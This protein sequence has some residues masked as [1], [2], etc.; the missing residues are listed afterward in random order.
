MYN[1]LYD[2]SGTQTTDRIFVHCTMSFGIRC[3]K[4][5]IWNQSSSGGAFS[6]GLFNSAPS[7]QVISLNHKAWN[8]AI[9][10]FTWPR[11][12]S[13]V[14]SLVN[15]FYIFSLHL[16]TWCCV[17]GNPGDFPFEM[18]LLLFMIAAIV[19]G[20]NLIFYKCKSP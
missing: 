4:R 17:D 16:I 13:I 8:T 2:L 10:Y 3:N 7:I 15:L 9:V 19:T 1:A 11:P 5:T 20:I 18:F 14:K 12:N 6:P